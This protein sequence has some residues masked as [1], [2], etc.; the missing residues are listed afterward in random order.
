MPWLY[1][2]ISIKLLTKSRRL[3]CC[4]WGNVLYA[5]DSYKEIAF[6]LSLSARSN[7]ACIFFALVCATTLACFCSLV[8]M[9]MDRY[10]PSEDNSKQP[11]A[12]CPYLPDI[13]LKKN[14]H[15]SVTLSCGHDVIHA[16]PVI[17]SISTV[18]FLSAGILNILS[19]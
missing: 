5:S 2:Y 3:F 14:T 18:G 9:W 1:F 11:Y 8:V 6:F 4:S 16:K 10:E 7:S 13:T 12:T 19:R 17:L 15:I